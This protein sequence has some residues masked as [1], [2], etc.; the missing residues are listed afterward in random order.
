M[1]Y[2]LGFFYKVFFILK[3]VNHKML[4]WMVWKLS[5][6][7]ELILFRF[8]EIEI[9]DLS[10]QRIQSCRSDSEESG[11]RDNGQEPHEDGQG[12]VISSAFLF[13]ALCGC[14][15][16][17]DYYT[18]AFYLILLSYFSNLTWWLKL[19]R[20]GSRWISPKCLRHQR[21]KV[22]LVFWDAL[23]LGKM[24]Y[25]QTVMDHLYQWMELKNL[26]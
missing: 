8:W 19:C 9:A 5:F 13:S 22:T 23:I 24:F 15:D 11:R 18:R 10:T 21:H 26:F 6:W 12:I 25:M 17:L 4:R 14:F 7:F 20:M 1:A 16:L 3:L 2:E